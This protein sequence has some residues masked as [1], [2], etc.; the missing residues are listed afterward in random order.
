M[1]H[2]WPVILSLVTHCAQCQQPAGVLAIL[3]G[4]LFR[5]CSWLQLQVVFRRQNFTSLPQPLPLTLSPPCLPSCSLSP[6]HDGRM[7]RLRYEQWVS[8]LSSLMPG[9]RS[10]LL[11]ARMLQQWI[12]AARNL[13]NCSIYP[14]IPRESPIVYFLLLRTIS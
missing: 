14:I 2:S 13:S 3:Q 1:L 9:C 6:G 5:S 7:C 4:W 12:Y 8:S 11:V 10:S